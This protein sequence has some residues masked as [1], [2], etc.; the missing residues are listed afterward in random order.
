MLQVRKSHSC[1]VSWIFF[2]CC[3]MIE[4]QVLMT[5]SDFLKFFPRNHFLEEGFAVQWG[6]VVF[7]MGGFIFKWV[8]PHWGHWFWWEV[9]KKI[10]GWGIAPHAPLSMG[11]PEA[12]RPLLGNKE[13]NLILR[14]SKM[15][16]SLLWEYNN[17]KKINIGRKAQP[18]NV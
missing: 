3:F 10:V 17:F 8:A 9:F 14:T 12:C 16:V 11:N 7:Q 2:Q 15:P 6:G 1:G 4:A 13:K 5:V 18:V